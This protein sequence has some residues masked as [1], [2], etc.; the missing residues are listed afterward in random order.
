MISYSAKDLPQDSLDVIIKTADI[1]YREYEDDNTKTAYILS[2]TE[3]EKAR[4]LLDSY[5]T[6]K[7]YL[8]DT[9]GITSYVGDRDEYVLSIYSSY[10]FNQDDPYSRMNKYY[11]VIH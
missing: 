9:Y 1:V 3:M 8:N 7:E 4:S 6:N 2:H 5:L 10:W 11:A